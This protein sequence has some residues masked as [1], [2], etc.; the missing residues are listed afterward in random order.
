MPS[1]VNLFPS[2]DKVVNNVE[3]DYTLQIA[4]QECAAGKE[5][6]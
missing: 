6:N 2:N 3:A 4:S 1:V 5:S